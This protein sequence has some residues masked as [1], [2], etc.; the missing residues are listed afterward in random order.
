MT[1]AV[2]TQNDTVWIRANY[3]VAPLNA[4]LSGWVNELQHALKSG[5]AAYPDTSRR[6]FYDVELPSGWA[7]IHILDNKE[8]VYLV[9][10]SLL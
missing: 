5:L 4:R 2:A 10:Y 1:A 6:N 3:H 8:T 9:A 7:Y